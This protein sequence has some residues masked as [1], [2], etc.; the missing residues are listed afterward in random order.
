MIFHRGYRPPDRVW[1]GQMTCES[2]LLFMKAGTRGNPAY[3]AVMDR[4]CLLS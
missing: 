3:G 4:G 2:S 1:A